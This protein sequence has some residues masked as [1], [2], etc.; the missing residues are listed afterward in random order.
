MKKE[1]VQPGKSVA[2]FDKKSKLVYGG[3]CARQLLG[4]PEGINTKI[5]PFDHGHYE[6][7]LQSTSVNRKLPSHTKVLIDLNKLTNSK[8]TW[9]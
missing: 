5:S 8:P 3:K 1:L 7:F 6:I 9:E 2:I 4:L